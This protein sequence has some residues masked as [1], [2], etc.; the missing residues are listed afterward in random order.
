MGL[1]KQEGIELSKTDD[2][3][4]FNST[5]GLRISPTS[6]WYHSA[7]LN[8]NTQ[9]TNGYNYPNRL[10]ILFLCLLRPH[11]YFLGIGSEYIY[12]P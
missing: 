7:K 1:N 8:F 10:R 5:Y 6:D 9:F 4:K 3:F 12:K 11:M 2:A